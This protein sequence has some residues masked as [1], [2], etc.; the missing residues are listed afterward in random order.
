MEQ[1]GEFLRFY[2]DW[3]AEAPNELMT[4]IVHWKAPPP[5][6]APAQLHGKPVVMVTCC[7]AGD[8]EEGEQF[9]R[10]L[11]EFGSPVADVCAP[12]PYLTHQAMFDPSFV[13][14]RWYYFKSCDVG[15]AE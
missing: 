3:V 5:P 4:I 10:P 13:P 2:G 11:K 15:G 1:S 7:S 12:K 9:I 8:V 6:F 14:G